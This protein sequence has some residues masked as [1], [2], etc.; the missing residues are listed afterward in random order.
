MV[1]PGLGEV[2]GEGLVLRK[3]RL[4][5]GLGADRAVPELGCARELGCSQVTAS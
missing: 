3:D 5:G 4:L 2:T 1:E